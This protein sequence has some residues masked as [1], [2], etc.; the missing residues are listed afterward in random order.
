MRIL[1]VDDEPHL[2]DILYKS[3]KEEGYSVDVTRN[4]MDGYEYAKTGVYDVIILDIMLPGMDGIEVLKN[5]R[6]IGINTPVL[7]LTA[8]DATEDKV[9]GLDSGADDYLTKPFELS[10]LLAR[11]RALL[12]RESE[13][14][15]PILK[16]GDLELNT[17]THQVKRAGREITL[18]S[19]EYAMLEYLMRNANRVLSRSQIADHVWDYEF[20]GLSNIIDVYIRYLRKKI[21]DDFPVKLIH[22]VRGSGYCL[23]GS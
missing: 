4:G 11:V 3:L 19:K 23:K 9:N 6:N 1:V 5:L 22:T 17:L 7:M 14:K 10:E 13:N 21:D 18:T 15:S 8:K 16:V 12:R 2:T 20:D